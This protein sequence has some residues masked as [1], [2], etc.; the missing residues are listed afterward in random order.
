MKCSLTGHLL[1]VLEYKCL[2]SADKFYSI[3]QNK[4]FHYL[5]LYLIYISLSY[6]DTLKFNIVKIKIRNQKK[7]LKINAKVNNERLDKNMFIPIPKGT[8]RQEPNKITEGMHSIA[9]DLRRI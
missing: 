5:V 1:S 3:N 8:D 7:N 6:S 9:W 2:S 4:W